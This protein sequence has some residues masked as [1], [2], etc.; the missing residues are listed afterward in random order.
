MK[1]EI[2]ELLYASDTDLWPSVHVPTVC[3]RIRYIYT[4]GF[5]TRCKVEIIYCLISLI[6]GLHNLKSKTN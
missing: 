1:D 4:D 5:F 3:R 6:S 2:N